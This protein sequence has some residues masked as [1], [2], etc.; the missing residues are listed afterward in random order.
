[1]GSPSPA[2]FDANAPDPI[3]SA[4]LENSGTQ[5]RFGSTPIERAGLDD[6]YKVGYGRQSTQQSRDSAFFL[7]PEARAARGAEIH[8]DLN[9]PPMANPLAVPAISPVAPIAPPIPASPVSGPIGS[10]SPGVRDTGSFGGNVAGSNA[11][12]EEFSRPF[13]PSTA[14]PFLP[15][16]LTGPYGN[17]MTDAADLK[18]N[19]AL[20]APSDSAEHRALVAQYTPAPVVTDPTAN[21]NTQRYAGTGFAVPT[22]YGTVGSRTASPGETLPKATVTKTGVQRARGTVP[23]LAGSDTSQMNPYA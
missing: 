15:P 17:A 5:R 13:V 4:R 14:K 3:A 18:Q 9:Q 20:A 7:S 6:R 10:V 12:G 23:Q 8:A 19:Q 2:R 1:M 22:P 11:A 16:S 21:A